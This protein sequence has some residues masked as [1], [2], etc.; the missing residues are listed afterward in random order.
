MFIPQCNVCVYET[1]K[2]TKGSMEKRCSN[3]INIFLNEI[4]KGNH[5][6]NHVWEPLA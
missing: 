5:V 2:E 6:A 1:K 3:I 4:L